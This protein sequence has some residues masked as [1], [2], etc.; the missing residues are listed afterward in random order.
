MDAIAHRLIFALAQSPHFRRVRERGELAHLPRDLEALSLENLDVDDSTLEAL[1]YFPR[2]R[3]LDLDGTA[4]SDETLRWVARQSLLE[5]LWLECTDLTDAGLLQL[6]TLSRLRF[7]SLAHVGVTGS[8][9]A[10]L[11]SALPGLEVSA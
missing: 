1:P 6:R 2:L 3:C 7:V 9:V 8:G 11:R 10:A 4:I 5:E